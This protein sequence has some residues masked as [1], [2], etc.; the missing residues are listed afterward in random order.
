[1]GGSTRLGSVVLGVLAI[2]AVAAAAHA[3]G[4]DTGSLRGRITDN[5]GASL[6]GVTVTAA[7]G[8]VM[9]GS[10]VA[11][12]SD[13]GMYRFPALP[14]GLYT[15]RME[16]TGFSP[17]VIEGLRITVGLGLTIDRQ[18]ALANIQESVTVVGESPI[19]DTR[20]TE[21]GATVTKEILEMVP[22]SRDLWNTV[23]QVPGLVVPRENVG[24]FESTQ[25]SAMSVHGSGA[26]A[27]QHNVNG[28]DMTLM[29]QD[30]LG[31]G[32]MSTDAFEEVQV[33][34]SGISAEHSRGGLIINQVVRSGSN[35]LRGST[36]FYYENDS[37][38]SANVDDDL[39]SRG[40]LSEG[41]P[42][43]K[44]RD[45][46]AQL[47]GPIAHDRLWFFAAFRQYNVLPFVLNCFLADG[48]QCT[49]EAR[50]RNYTGKLNAQAGPA[51][52]F[53]FFYEWGQKFM[54]NRD[55]SQFIRPEASYKQDG[56]HEIIQARYDRILSPTLL[57]ESSYGQLESPFP[58]RYRDEVG[59]TTTRFDEVTRIRSDAAFQ[60]FFQRGQMQT[61]RSNVS[62]FNDHLIG[63]AHDLKI[64]GEWRHGEVP[65]TTARNGDLQRIYRNGLPA[66]VWVYNT[67]VERNA[68]NRAIM[69]FVQDSASYGRLT[70]TLGLR[71]EDWTGWLPEQA[72]NP[73]SYA[74]VFGGAK[75]FAEQKDLIAWTTWSPRLGVIFDLF[76]N[77]RTIAKASF[78]RYFNQIEGNRINGVANSNGVAEARY[79]WADL[80]GNNY[81]E[82]NE[83]G[84]LRSISIPSARGAISPDLES[85]YSDEVSTSLEHALNQRMSVSVRYT[86]RKN[87][88]IL[89]EDDVALPDSAFTVPSVATDPLTGSPINYWSINPAIGTVRNNIILTQFD[90]NYTRYHGVDLVFDR[91]FDGRWLARG[92][93]TFQG[94]DGRVGGY[95]N[96][97]DREIFPYGAA[98]LDAKRLVRLQTAYVMPWD[99]NTAVTFRHTSGLNSFTAS[100]Q[101]PSPMA[102]VVQV[103]DRTNNQL[104]QIRVEEN[105]SYRQDPVSVLDLRAAKNFRLGRARIEGIFDLFNVFNAN[106]VLAA[107]TLTASNFDRPTVVL[108]PRVARVGVKFEF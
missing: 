79:D 42:L 62:W 74:A 64:G 94:N 51:N 70:A 37:T 76:G 14:P 54:P 96:R 58:L 15:V 91:R 53:L 40:V 16:L 26:S 46:S 72:N 23:Q 84:V 17:A 57:F 102:R 85:P 22:S 81:P 56:A 69:G 63:G 48:T 21:A 92:S 80:N 49:N 78:G 9:G 10:L 1:M 19:V 90:S 55:I 95:L 59:D 18:L 6:P 52:R 77:S 83:F 44:L 89:A 108:T 68:E 75:T 66:Q 61:F 106:N 71:V 50:L 97:N 38:M 88:K 100:A 33:S 4:T 101:S 2:V 105:G 11:V 103:P 99:I 32:Y 43:D 36:A 8:A 87:G 104:Y 25:L 45:F 41:S 34:T 13:E 82:A 27:V 67:P 3:Q 107:G 12:T 31:A 20:H 65:E 47:G 30:N 39:R 29:H 28:I 35:Q 93:V 60:N 98:G 5:T 24:G 86:Y 73:A 7:S